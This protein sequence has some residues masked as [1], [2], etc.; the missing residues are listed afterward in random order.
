MTKKNILPNFLT[1]TLI[2]TISGIVVK[3]I[4]SLN[5]IIISRSLGG[6]GIGL[7]QMGF[8]VYLLALSISSAG[9]P[10]AISIITAEKLAKSDY[11]G[12]KRVFRTSLYFLFATGLIF[13]LALVVGAK[14]L[15]QWNLL[16]DARAYYSIIALAP[17]VFFVTFLASFRGYLQGWQNMKPTAVSE[18]VEQLLRVVT[19]IVLAQMLLPYGIEFAAA[20]AS[21][22]AAVG[23]VGGLL[24]LMYFYRKL[25]VQ[26]QQKH[27]EQSLYVV[28]ESSGAII[29]RLLKLALPV[30]ISSLMLPVV[31]NLD[32]LIV[33]VRLESAGYTISQ[34]TEL[35]GYLT[36]MAVPLVNLS[37][38][39]TAA[40]SISLVP[41]ISKL[42]TLRQTAEINKQVNTAFSVASIITIPCSVGLC[43]LAQPIAMLIYN[44]PLAAQTIQVMS[45]GI[46]LLGLHQVST[47][48]LQG[49]S[50]TSIPVW[51]MVLAA[52][53]KVVLNFYLTA[54]PSL[55]INGAAVATIVDIGLAAMLNLVFIYKY[56]GYMPNMWQLTKIAVASA[57]MGVAVYYTVHINM[58][59]AW[60]MLL[61][62]IL[63]V[64]VYAISIL[65]LGG[66]DADAL[67]KIP[68]VGARL[69]PLYKKIHK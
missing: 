5:W 20:G 1:G 65:A 60:S 55:G 44:A 22:G 31:A 51:N 63:G 11:S 36:G 3:V 34:A 64:T 62:I 45:G 32:M 30:S 49:L 59:G 41:S 13:S 42:N 27:L 58:L 23:A 9:V 14:F 67:A 7:Y 66:I 15:V 38:I 61:S 35:F 50:R 40:L 56:T 53:F 18:I 54:M 19:M 24:V 48:I 10:V 68:F 57:A 4:G 17:A 26:M 52:A 6:E 16:R 37:T 12:A 39:L 25:K 2:L 29:K 69:L 46:F 33:P 8:P 28:P 21:L 47:G 43:L